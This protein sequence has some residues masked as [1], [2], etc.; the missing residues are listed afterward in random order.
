[1]DVYVPYKNP[2]QSFAREF[3]KLN[4]FIITIEHKLS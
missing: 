3:I 2:V 1:M 4:F